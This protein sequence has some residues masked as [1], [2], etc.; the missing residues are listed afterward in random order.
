MQEDKHS[1]KNSPLA[2][3]SAA[4]DQHFPRR[5]QSPASLSLDMPHLSRYNIPDYGKELA[6]CKLKSNRHSKH[7][8]NIERHFPESATYQYSMP[9]SQVQKHLITLLMDTFNIIIIPILHKLFANDLQVSTKGAE[10]DHS[11]MT[12]Q[13]TGNSHKPGNA[14]WQ[15]YH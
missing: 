14:D 1:E 9:H 11:I 7:R 15:I 5:K 6:A 4:R 8:K 10:L 12:D 3:T 13:C 2:Y